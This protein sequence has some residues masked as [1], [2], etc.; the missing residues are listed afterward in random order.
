MTRRVTAIALAAIAAARH[1]G[2]PVTEGIRA[3]QSFR[4]VKRRMELRGRVDDIAVY[5]D[6]AHHPT[7]IATTLDGLRRA[8]RRGRI[9]AVVEPRSNTMKL[10][11]MKAI[12]EKYGGKE[13]VWLA[14]NSTK[15]ATAQGNKQWIT[16]HALTYP[17][18][19]DDDFAIWRALDNDAWPAKYLFDR[20]GRLVKR[21]IGEG[22]YHTLLRVAVMTKQG[23]RAVAGTLFGDSAP[24]LVDMFGV[25]IEAELSGEMVYI[26][27]EDN[28][29]WTF[30]SQL[31]NLGRDRFL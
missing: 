31:F 9:L 4:G 13:V 28:V 11:T 26:V 24:R 19:I 1:A 23:R 25:A 10:G 21:W 8:E 6:F 20:N 3:L 30:Y 16:Q 27:N 18:A 5:D 15:S 29:R 7:A 17:I 22:A 14:I 2:V 12:A